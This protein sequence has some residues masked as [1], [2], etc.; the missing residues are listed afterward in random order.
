MSHASYVHTYYDV[1]FQINYD[2]SIS[3][4]SVA[5]YRTLQD[6]RDERIA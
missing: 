6:E 2:S 1:E 4:L 5:P 3:V